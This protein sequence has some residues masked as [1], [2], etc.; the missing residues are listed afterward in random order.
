MLRLSDIACRS[1]RRVRKISIAIALVVVIATIDA[2]A[3]TWEVNSHVSV[4]RLYLGS[5][6]NATE[7]GV[8]RIS[9][10][11]VFDADRPA[12]PTVDFKI[13]QGDE[14]GSQSVRIRFI[15]K[16]SVMTSDGKLIVKGNLAVTR[17]E[18]SMTMDPS[19]AFAGP[20]YGEPVEHTEIHP[21]TVVFYL[22]RQSPAYNSTIQLS[23]TTSVAR[24]NFPQFLDALNL[25][26][27]PTQLV[28]DRKCNLPL[29]VGEDFSGAKCTGTLIASV[30]NVEVK[31][32]SGEAFSGFRPAIAPDLNH[33]TLTM[34]LRLT[35]VESAHSS[36][37]AA[38]ATLT[39]KPVALLMTDLGVTKTHSRSHVSD[40]NPYSE[41]LLLF[42]TR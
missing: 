39:S 28:N 27:W 25:I 11:V 17:F 34:D 9:G 41:S 38:A 37:S 14:T 30:S 2:Q 1:M 3:E 32:G 6:S 4:A 19:E 20:V 15:S 23:G 12:N 5:E 29:T 33:G 8:A 40:D 31:I 22:L 21:I 7:I 24:S 13:V 42:S 18:R 36:A 10:Q 16:H 26:N 35:E